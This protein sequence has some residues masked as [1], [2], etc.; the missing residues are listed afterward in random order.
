MGS[1]REPDSDAKKQK[2]GGKEAGC[3][4]LFGKQKQHV[5]DCF[6]LLYTWC[7]IFRIEYTFLIFRL[8]EIEKGRGRSL[9]FTDL[10]CRVFSTTHP[11]HTHALCPQENSVEGESRVPQSPWTR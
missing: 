7:G 9:N 10:L 1:D 8:G 4:F 5:W 11:T 2:R 6:A 3:L